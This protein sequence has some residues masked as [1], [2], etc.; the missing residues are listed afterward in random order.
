MLSF[1]KDDYVRK[2]SLA[3]K[4]RRESIEK[5][6]LHTESLR[7]RLSGFQRLQNRINEMVRDNC[8]QHIL[9]TCHNQ[10]LH[11]GTS[12]R[13]PDSMSL[14]AAAICLAMESGPCGLQMAFILQL[15]NVSM[16]NA[17]MLLEEERPGSGKAA[18]KTRKDAAA[19]AAKKSG[20]KAKKAAAQ[21][22]QA[23]RGQSTPHM[24]RR[25]HLL[26]LAESIRRLDLSQPCPC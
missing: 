14:S 20:S 25:C 23:G 5:V 26:L 13:H 17:L 16:H 1:R 22:K 19:A 8:Q 3:C 4:L 11:L 7:G 21:P 12:L 18:K 2:A 9:A 24:V 15:E 10:A 6:Q